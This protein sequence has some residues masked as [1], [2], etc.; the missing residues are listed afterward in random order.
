[1]R[2]GFWKAV[3]LLAMAAALLAL[4]G[5]ALAEAT[6]N[7]QWTMYVDRDTLS[8]YAEQ[9]K[10]AKVVKTLKGGAKLTVE[11][12]YGSW[13]GIYYE[14]KSGKE[15]VGYVLSKYL[16]GVMPSRYCKHKWSAWE[17]YREAT[18]S[19]KGMR[20]RSCSVCGVGESKDIKK[21]DHEYGKW[22]VEREA[23]CSEEGER[24]RECKNCGH[25]Q[26]QAIDRADHTYSRW[27]VREE[28][29]CTEK[30]EEYR[31]CEVCGHTQTRAI[32][33]IPHEYG[34]WI[35]LVEPAC[36]EKG[37]R[38]RRCVMCGDRDVEELDMVDH[39]YGRGTVTREA[40]C[41]EEGRRSRSCA[42]CGKRETQAIGM[43]P[44]EYGRWTV[45]REATCTR[46]GRRVRTCLVCGTE[47]VQSIDMLPHQYQWK[48][49]ILST[50]HSAGVR[51]RICTVCGNVAQEESFDPAGTLRRGARGEDVREIQQLL[52][53]QGYLAA[54]GIDGIFG[55][56]LERAIL[57]FQRDQGL[58]ADGVAWPQTIRRL[59]HEFG[60]WSTL[61]ELTRSQDGE[62]VRTCVDCGYQQYETVSAGEEIPKGTRSEAVRTL[63]RMLN[64]LGYPAGT[65][66]GAYGPK[67]DNAYDAFAAERGFSFIPGALTPED[68]DALVNGWIQGLPAGDWQGRGG[69]ND[70]VR[71]VLTVTEDAA[72]PDEAMPG[73]RTFTWRLMNLGSENCRFEALLLAFGE[74]A[75]FRSDVLALTVD[76]VELRRDGANTAEGQFSVSESWG[77]GRLNF[78]A[79]GESGKTGKVW[80]SNTRAFE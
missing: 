52:S 38:V 77:A 26:T 64:D 61:T 41:T 25:V 71:L 33:R 39:E 62:Y 50:D 3:A 72:D 17:V 79:L 27:I 5:S 19:E 48:T 45:T 6:A 10:S 23:T 68:V 22:V 43:L 44:H 59:H 24:Y 8:V 2:N 74:G 20:I 49:T 55:G 70:P 63:Q 69:K 30:G 35:T 7:E 14:T 12:D 37:V 51:S 11:G 36:T 34:T 13:T 65:A 28:A 32:D 18:C 16:S 1:M 54:G 4:T 66:D 31:K 53:D 78:S 29:T 73:V 60:P 9:D 42:V 46:K 40:P 75:D 76:G 67:L 57:Q 80:L 21:L 15:K 56:G 47:D 58:T